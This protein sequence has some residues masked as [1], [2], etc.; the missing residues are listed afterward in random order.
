[1][2]SW[3]KIRT[4]ISLQENEFENVVFKK[5]AM[6]AEFSVISKDGCRVTSGG[7]PPQVIQ[8]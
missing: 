1:M 4:N 5:S 3:I 6:F 8:Y 7:C 2:E